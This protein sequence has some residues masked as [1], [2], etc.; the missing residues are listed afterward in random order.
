MARESCSIGLCD[1]GLIHAF[2]DLDDGVAEEPLCGSGARFAD[3]GGEEDP[4]CGACVP[5][6]A[7]EL[8]I[9]PVAFANDC[10]VPYPSA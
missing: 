10:G 1:D 3:S 7:V 9:D 5:L 6:I 4:I 2:A 8:G